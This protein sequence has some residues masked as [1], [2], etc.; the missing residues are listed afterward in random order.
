MRRL[1]AIVAGLVLFVG[2]GAASAQTP[3]DLVP[4]KTLAYIELQYPAALAKELAALLEGSYL[5]DV[6]DSLAPLHAKV[7]GPRRPG[8]GA[9]PSAGQWRDPLGMVGVV[10]AP[11][12]LK[13][14]GR[15]KGAAVAVTGIGTDV[16]MP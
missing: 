2:G 10:L 5:A 3:A 14:F 8:L 11:E 1:V 15:L 6:P 4:A 9:P 16:G 13:G 12:M 7:R